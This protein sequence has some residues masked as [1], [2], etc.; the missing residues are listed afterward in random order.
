VKEGL[1][2]YRDLKGVIDTSFEDG[3]IEGKIEGEKGKALEVAR[4]MKQDGF[5]VDMIVKYTGLKKE[6]VE[7]LE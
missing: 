6:D 3:K 4:K 5:S 7:N 1:K 2:V